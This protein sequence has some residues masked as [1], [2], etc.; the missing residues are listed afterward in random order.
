MAEFASRS[1]RWNGSQIRSR[2]DAGIPGP[3]SS[4]QMRADRPSVASVEADGDR[5]SARAVFDG[6]VEQIDEDLP[7]RAAIDLGDDVVVETNPYLHVTRGG[8]WRERLE[9]F[10]HEWRQLRLL[11]HERILTTLDAIEAQYFVD[12]MAK[13][14]RFLIDDVE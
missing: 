5:L 2:S 3:S 14:S 1:R 9:H 7:H 11:G 4:T 6:V 12:E 8:E 10:T 13:P